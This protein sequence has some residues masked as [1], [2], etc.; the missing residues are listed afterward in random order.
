M[1]NEYRVI[2]IRYAYRV[3]V[4]GKLCWKTVNNAVWIAAMNI[5]DLPPT[6]SGIV[7]VVLD[8]DVVNVPR[9]IA[10]GCHNVHTL[11]LCTGI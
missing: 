8:S 3:A 5:N 9:N 2:Q 1:Q 7:G 10:V 11:S 4:V 6:S